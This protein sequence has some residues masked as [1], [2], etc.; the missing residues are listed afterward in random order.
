MEASQL[1]SDD[2]Y[3]SETQT[4]TSASKDQVEP[5]VISQ[6]QSPITPEF[7]PREIDFLNRHRQKIR[8]F[9]PKGVYEFRHIQQ[10][11]LHSLLQVVTM[12]I[13][14]ACMVGIYYWGYQSSKEIIVGVGEVSDL[15]WVNVFEVVMSVG[16]IFVAIRKLGKQAKQHPQK[17]YR[18]AMIANAF[19]RML[20]NNLR[21][22]LIVF[23]PLIIVAMIVDPTLQSINFERFEEGATA[24]LLGAVYTL[25]I[26]F[27][28]FR[29][30]R[31][32]GKE[33]AA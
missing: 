18:I 5:E 9:D 30:F 27:I 33:L 16:I 20:F 17:R 23:V 12:L 11:W 15:T 21:L 13:S 7:I 22:M 6:L 14:L 24:D 32:C 26:V 25:F 2:E 3:S 1:V 19:N 8:L 31:F 10:T 28:C 29:A 4:T